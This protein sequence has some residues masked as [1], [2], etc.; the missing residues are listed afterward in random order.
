MLLPIVR[1][2]PF[3]VSPAVPFDKGTEPRSVFPIVKLTLPVGGVVPVAGLTEAVRTVV[4]VEAMLVG[5]TVKLVVVATP[6]AVTLT[7]TK[8]VEL[9][10]LPVAI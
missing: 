6:G 10:K 3:T 2:L 9:T 8:P 1:L 7:V 5:A 4:A